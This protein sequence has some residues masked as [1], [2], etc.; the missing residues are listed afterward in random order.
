VIARALTGADSAQPGVRPGISRNGNEF[1]Y[2]APLKDGRDCPQTLPT[3]APSNRNTS[4][5]SAAAT[6]RTTQSDSGFT[7]FRDGCRGN[8]AP[9]ILLRLAGQPSNT[10]KLVLEHDMRVHVFVPKGSTY[11]QECGGFPTGNIAFGF[12]SLD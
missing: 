8:G 1:S 5:P 4:P 11:A 6:P 3:S 9:F 12:V 10:V 2:T 7:T